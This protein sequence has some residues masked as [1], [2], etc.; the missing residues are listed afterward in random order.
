M[1]VRR[2]KGANMQKTKSKSAK[3]STPSQTNLFRMNSTGAEL[4]RR[5]DCPLWERVSQIYALVILAMFPLMLIPQF[6]KNIASKFYYTMD[7]VV[8]DG[9]DVGT[10]GAYGLMEEVFG[11]GSPF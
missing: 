4:S 6:P 3:K 1:A 11:N 8:I 2:L 7:Q 9:V 5:T 10:I